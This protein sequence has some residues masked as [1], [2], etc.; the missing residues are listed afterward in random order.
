S[1]CNGADRHRTVVAGGIDD[2]HGRFRF[3][4]IIVTHEIHRVFEIV[5]RVAFQNPNIECSQPEL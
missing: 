1:S 3:T 2:L 5:D 4:G